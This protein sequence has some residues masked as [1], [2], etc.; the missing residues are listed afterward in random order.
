MA[1]FTITIENLDKLQ[2]AL[3]NYPSI[4]EPILQKAIDGT[5]FALQKN[6]LKSDP[7]PWKTGNLLQS[8]RFKPGNLQARWGPTANYAPMVEFGTRPHAIFPR[9]K[10][11]LAWGSGGT[12]GKYV[13]AAS[14]R[15]YYKG[16]SG[17]TTIFAMHVNHPGTKP[18]PFMQKIVDKSVS[19]INRLFEQAGN[20]ITRAIAS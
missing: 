6:T 2:S 18:H 11:V 5:Q 19:D 14:G 12:G 10:R 9:N 20:L 16:A 1:D 13:T 15:Q 4:A 3:K 7:V 17:G 8:F